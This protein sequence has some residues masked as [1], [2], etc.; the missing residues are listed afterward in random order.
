MKPKLI[1]DIN[2][3]EMPVGMLIGYAARTHMEKVRA[4]LE[5]LGI[6]KTSGPILKALS[7]D[8]G[9][10]QGEL[11][12][13]MFISAPSMSV[14]LQ[15]MEAAGLLLRKTDNTDMRQNRLFLSEKGRATADKAENEIA[16]VEKAF[17]EALTPEERVEFRRLLVKALKSQME[18]T[19]IE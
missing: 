18:R 6:Q 14:N 2:L 7:G 17:L 12:D 5:N 4:S 8:E 3:E 16:R 10:T 9:M 19:G 11:A 13:N 1:T 15:K